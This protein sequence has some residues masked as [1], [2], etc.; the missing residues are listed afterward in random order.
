MSDRTIIV[1]RRI[2]GHEYLLSALVVGVCTVVSLL[3]RP[4]L[5]PTNLVMVYFVGVLAIAT[6]CSKGAAM[7]TS[8]LSVAA[9]DFFCVPPYYTFVVAQSEYVITFAVMLVV[10]VL[11][12]AMTA[13]IRL[14]T[15]ASVEREIQTAALYRLSVELAGRSRAFDIAKSA[16]ALAEETFRLRVTTFLCGDDGQILFSRRTSDHLYVPTAEQEIAQW[17]FDHGRNAGIGTKTY[18][19]ASALYIPIKGVGAIYGVMAVSP[20]T[21]LLPEH[22]HLLE[23]FAS[24]T[25]LAIE[26]AIAASAAKSA[27]VRAETENMRTSLLSAVSHDLRNPLA[28]ITGAAATLRTHWDRLEDNVRDELLQSVTDEAER[29]N[30]LLNNLL[31]VTRLE[32]GVYLH[33]ESFPLE[34]VVGA[35]LHRLQ[36]QLLG[37]RVLTDIPSGL[38]MVAMDDVLMEQV[39][40]NLVENALKYTPPGTDI[41]IAA[42]T[43]GDML[44]V[45]VQDS[46]PGFKEGEEE[47]VFE[48]FFRGRT[49]NIRGAGL[50]LAICRAIVEAHGGSISA[51]NRPGGGAIIHFTIP[52]SDT[53]PAFATQQRSEM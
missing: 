52:M 1:N 11:I 9:F 28:T 49:D 32:G 41:E 13:Q 38:P 31:E 20:S 4:H 12:S 17:V 45:Q 19:H 48:K 15:A 27:E 33:K 6:R 43:H 53:K 40:I 2:P 47:R 46:G 3:L 35:A 37:R 7:L 42:S 24:Q 8:V 34:E 5:N 16:A 44:E 10:A 51:R 25:A 14:Q 22:Q 29:L 26:R 30:R 36:R 50:G 39:F 18:P 21:H 23:I